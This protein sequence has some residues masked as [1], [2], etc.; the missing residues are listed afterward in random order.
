MCFWLFGLSRGDPGKTDVSLLPEH[1]CQ[2]IKL[3]HQGTLTQDNLNSSM[4]QHKT[5]KTLA[6]C[7][8]F[9]IYIH[10]NILTSLNC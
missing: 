5:I 6:E 7:L 10:I 9:I 1:T 3:N 2:L 8:S 4:E